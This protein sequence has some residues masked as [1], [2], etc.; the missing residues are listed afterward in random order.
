M[1]VVYEHWLDNKCFCVGH[2]TKYRPKNF[3]SRKR[4]WKEYVNGREKD[5]IVKIVKT[6]DTKEEAYAYEIE[7]H[8][9]MVLKGYPIQNLL[10]NSGYWTGKKRPDIH[11]KLVKS[12]TGR[13]LS[14]EHKL[15]IS[16]NN[17]RGNLGKSMPEERKKKLSE[18]IKNKYINDEEYRNKI[19]FAQRRR[20]QLE[21]DN[22]CTNTI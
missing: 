5:V 3:G 7:H 18:A 16:Q 20:R 14:E 12:L 15:H 1:Y 9:E 4:A 10:G 21:K 13:H 6:F 11:D 2:G 8:K 17:G 22:C 19:I